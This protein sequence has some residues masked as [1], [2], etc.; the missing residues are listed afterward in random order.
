V[1][2]VPSPAD[3]AL[4]T[5]RAA[6]HGAL[7]AVR[8]DRGLLLFSGKDAADLLHRLSTNALRDLRPG[9]GCATVFTTAKGRILDRALVHALDEGL[10]LV[11]G[12]GRAA[13]LA[14][15][16]ERYTFR[17]EV[18][19]EDRGATHAV[20]GLYGAGAAAV[21]SRLFGPEAAALP[22]HHARRCALGGARVLAAATDPLGG[23]GFHLIAERPDLGAIESAARE[24][25][26]VPADPAGLETLRIEAGLPEHG[27]ELTEDH[28]PWEARLQDDISLVKGCYVGQEV[29]AR[30]NTYR[31]VAR[32]LVRLDV[33]GPP[34]AAGAAVQSGGEPIGSVTS[35]AAVPGS[36]RSVA[37]AYVRDEDA[38]PGKEVAIDGCGPARVEG[39][40]R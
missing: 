24:A 26:A 30:L 23:G 6:R 38:V 35:A 17:E 10:L 39:P 16:V 7:C 2:G 3:A 27:R 25:G 1:T 37:L 34:P 8:P 36:A 12:P 29:I 15:W 32:L 19:A 31:K 4:A 9:Q 40:A 11:T 28:N 14:A 33:P 18:R 5:Y 22:R 20:V 13:P 21:V